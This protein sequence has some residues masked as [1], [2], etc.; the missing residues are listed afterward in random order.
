MALSNANSPHESIGWGVR[1]CRCGGDGHFIVCQ[2]LLQGTH[3]ALAGDLADIQ[4]DQ[5]LGVPTN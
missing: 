1:R 3:F 5:Y 4:L 2:I